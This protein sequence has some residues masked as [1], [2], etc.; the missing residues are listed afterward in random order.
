MPTDRLNRIDAPVSSLKL[1]VLSPLLDDVLDSR[2][3]EAMDAHPLL[4]RNPPQLIVDRLRK[5][6]RDG[7]G[8]SSGGDA[9]ELAV[10]TASAASIDPLRAPKP[11]FFAV[12]MRASFRACALA[13]SECGM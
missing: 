2:Q 5:A 1:S 12:F 6:N 13:T 9:S 3:D 8:F 10:L 7:D 4:V 11:G